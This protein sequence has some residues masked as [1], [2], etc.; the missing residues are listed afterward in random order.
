MTFSTVGYGD[1]IPHSIDQRMI[2][3]TL[4]IVGVGVTA[5]I[6]GILA[7]LHVEDLE[8]SA[9]AGRASRCNKHVPRRSG[10]DVGVGGGGSVAETGDE[11]GPGPKSSISSLTDSV[12]N[13]SMH[14]KDAHRTKR[15]AA[16]PVVRAGL[17]CIWSS[18][19]GAVLRWMGALL[20]DL[21][22]RARVVFDR[23]TC[24][25]EP[26]LIVSPTMQAAAASASA[27][28]QQS[29]LNQALLNQDAAGPAATPISEKQH[30]SAAEEFR[31]LSTP[32][33]LTSRHVV[34]VN[35][36]RRIIRSYY[37]ELQDLRWTGCK[38]F[39]FLWTII[40][41][42]IFSMRAI[43]DFRPADS[44][45]WAIVTVTTVGYGDVVPV[46]TAGKAF[47]IV[48]I[49]VGTV[50]MGR[51][52]GNIV[53]SPMAMRAK[54]N[55]IA[56]MAQFELNLSEHQLHALLNN[57]LFTSIPH[58]YQQSNQISKAEFVS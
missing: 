37:R 48:Y 50:L 57:E 43:E 1:I 52:L 22:V 10:I 47:T 6:V 30:E 4:I 26:D 19:L 40:L 12:G 33:L 36:I 49:M 16:F 42:G 54:K 31:H 27:T 21:D 39:V 25:Y 17:E 7:A 11:E 29:P 38:D 44:F 46:T 8:S 55:E 41:V 2:T 45:Y 9:A 23:V 13:P 20:D 5:N 53:M 58:F 32:K 34:A 18:P 35:R 3:C 14:A 24:Y 51:T 15:E 56:V 28:S